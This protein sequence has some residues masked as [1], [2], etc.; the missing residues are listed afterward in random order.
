MK[1]FLFV[2]TLIAFLSACQTESVFPDLTY[3]CECGTVVWD[4]SSIDLTDSHYITTATD[5]T[6]LGLQFDLGKDYFITAEIDNEEDLE[7]HHLNMKISVPDLTLG[8]QN[9]FGGPICY[10]FEEGIFSVLIEEVD[11]NSLSTVDTYAVG[12]GNMTIASELGSTVDNITFEFEVF[13]TVGGSAA[14]QPFLY[15]GTFISEKEEL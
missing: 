13:L 4:D 2:L 14:G 15:S 12:A 8:I 10:D 3:R 1:R 7:A 11:F 6:K 5:T 9:D